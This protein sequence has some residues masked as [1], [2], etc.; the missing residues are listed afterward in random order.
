M[1]KEE[2]RFPANFAWGAATASYQ[3]EGAANEDGKGKSIRDEF[4]HTPGNIADGLN[5]DVACDHYHRCDEDINLMAMMNIKN[6]RMSL[7]WPRILPEG[8]K[9]SGVNDKGLDFY[10]RLIDK[11]L[12]KDITPWVTLFH[13]D[14]PATLQHKGGF[15]NRE[16]I[17]AFCEYT[18]IATKRFGDRVK[19]WMTFNEPWVYSFCGHFQGVHAPG[20]KDL[21]TTLATAHNIMV[22][23]GKSIPIIRANVPNAK[24]GI[25]NNLAWIESA[26]HKKEDVDAARRW[27]LAFNKWFMDPIFGKGYPEEMVKWYGDLMPKIEADDFET[28]SVPTDFMGVNYYTR[29]LVAHDPNDSH[30]QAKQVYRAHIPRAEFEEWEITPESLYNVLIRIKEEYGNIP[31]YISENGTTCVD[32]KI[33]DDGCVHDPVRVEYLR[34]H[35]AAAWQAI[36]EG[37]DVR[38]YLLWSF[39]DNFEW[40]FGYTKRFGVVY[41]DYE[42]DLRRII[43]DSGHFLAEVCGKNG[44]SIT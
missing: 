41:I 29:R 39:C 8:T 44:F 15:A 31:V 36:Q 34:R 11:L 25:V 4:S 16:T 42:N 23:H 12:A 18:D 32:E 13:W 33:S 3:I 35:F 2:I 43:K 6:Y 10:D 40:G 37:A 27:D 14:L 26:T 5:G 9:A 7:A 30:I 38:G 19:N 24:A 20:I 17:H 21:R 22:A 1:Y 28:M